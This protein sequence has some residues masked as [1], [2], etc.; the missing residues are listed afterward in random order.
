MGNYEP[1]KF[2]LW[3]MMLALYA[4]GALF[5]LVMAK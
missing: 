3:H 2:K 5:V 1:P 4:A